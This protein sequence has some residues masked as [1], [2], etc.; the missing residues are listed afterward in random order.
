[1]YG[2][3]L[4]NDEDKLYRSRHDLAKHLEAADGDGE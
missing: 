3:M 2:R 4:L 1:L